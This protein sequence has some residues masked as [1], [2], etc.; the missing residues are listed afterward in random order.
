MSTN[1]QEKRGGLVPIGTV[2]VRLP[3]VEGRGRAMSARSRHHFTTLRQVNQL[4]EASEA[5]PELGFMARLL[6]LCSLPRTNP[7]DREKYMRRNGPY[8]LVLTPPRTRRLGVF[9]KR[10]VNRRGFRRVNTTDRNARSIG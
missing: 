9:H 8:V 10:A 6:A 2:A 4:I 1:D 7:R 5:E 3:G